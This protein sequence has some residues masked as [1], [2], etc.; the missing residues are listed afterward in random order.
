MRET[1]LKYFLNYRI[2]P[3]CKNSTNQSQRSIRLVNKER[4]LFPSPYNTRNVN[5][6]YVYL[7]ILRDEALFND[8]TAVGYLDIIN[9]NFIFKMLSKDC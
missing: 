5:S 7:W 9:T 8:Y 2:L 3:D 6:V 4:K 1:Q